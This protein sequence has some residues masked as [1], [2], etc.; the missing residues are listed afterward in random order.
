MKVRAKK[1]LTEEK[2]NILKEINKKRL[3]HKSVKKFEKRL[4]SS[5]KPQEWEEFYK[6]LYTNVTKDFGERA[7]NEYEDEENDNDDTSRWFAAALIYIIPVVKRRISEVVETSRDR[8]TNTINKVAEENGSITD[9][10]L[11]IEELYDHDIPIRSKAISTTE[12]I[13]A[14]NI[15]L[16]FAVK[17]LKGSIKKTWIAIMDDRTRE[18]HWKTNGEVRSIDEK[19][20]NGLMFPGDPTAPAEEVCNCRCIESFII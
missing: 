13:T 16:R 5:I 10:I 4:V 18:S 9:L 17:S 11:A 6:Y 20:S 2:N 7:L 1:V 15:G 8:L 14:C 19:Y 3:D 12:V